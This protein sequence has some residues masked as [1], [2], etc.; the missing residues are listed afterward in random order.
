[1]KH[2]RRDFLKVG[3][4]GLS[5]LT[6]PE[7]AFGQDNNSEKSLVW[8]WLGGGPTQFETF[9]ANK[10]DV[11]EEYR[12]QTDFIYDSKTNINLGGLWTNLAKHFPKLNV[13][14]SFTH[15]DSSHLH[16]TH[17]M[18]TGHYGSER[19]DTAMSKYPSFG[20]LVSSVYGTND[21]KNGIP[22]YV[23]AGGKI[24]GDDPVWLGGAYKP[25]DPSTKEN[26]TPKIEVERFKDRKVLLDSF[27][28]SVASNSAKSI[29]F[30]KNQAYDVI[31]GSAKDAFDLTKETDKTKED[32]GKSTVGEQLLLARRLTEFGSKF[33]TIH[34][35]GWDM[36][37][38]VAKGMKERVPPLDK[39]LG[40]FLQDIWDR[41]L[42][43]KIMLVITGE[44]GR[45]KLNGTAGRDHW[46]AMTPM[47]MAGGKYPS[48]RTIGK[49]DK[50]YVAVD[51]PFGPLDL[52]ATIFDH[53]DIDGKQSKVDQGGRPRYLLDGDAKVIL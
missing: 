15:S 34:Y 25:F 37:S 2:N 22:T 17:F 47:L 16:A 27:G 45:T 30:Y 42:N 52:Q 26:L 14:N 4:A 18:M 43:E 48:G 39:A 51:K 38:E 31:L 12:S 1:M 7:L 19:A 20:S 40:A 41:G 28:Q 49:A 11:P 8:L 33:V 32:Y 3:G 29:D 53:F 6:L 36:H 21:S 35:G 10:D 24:E 44:F 13:V 23:K 9:H 46:S 50:S 5:Y